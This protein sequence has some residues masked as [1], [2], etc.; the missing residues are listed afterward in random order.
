MTKGKFAKRLHLLA[1]LGVLVP[2]Q[3]AHLE[4]LLKELHETREDHEAVE[5]GASDA[6]GG[7]HLHARN[8]ESLKRGSKGILEPKQHKKDELKRK[9]NM[10]AS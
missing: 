6:G 1:H 4:V 3:L 8:L 7:R 2:R 10:N 5:E 9:Q